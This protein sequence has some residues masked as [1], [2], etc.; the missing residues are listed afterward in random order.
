MRVA[1]ALTPDTEAT[2][3]TLP[4][5]STG[6][7]IASRHG[8]LAHKITRAR[9]ATNRTT[10]HSGRAPRPRRATTSTSNDYTRMQ[11]VDSCADIGCPSTTAAE[12]REAAVPWRPT[13]PPTRWRTCARATTAGAADHD[14]ENLPRSHCQSPYAHTTS[15][16]ME[17]VVAL[18]ATGTSYREIQ[19]GNTCGHCV[20]LW[21]A[22]VIETDGAGGR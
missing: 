3:P 22:C 9:R 8:A 7:L 11:I 5:V 21:R 2:S 19:C 14:K 13:I 17:T 18:L 12:S 10:A 15:G 1:R 4:G 16:K 20:V 6:G